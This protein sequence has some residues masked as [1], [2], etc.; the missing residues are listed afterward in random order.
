MCRPVGLGNFLAGYHRVLFSLA[1]RAP[2]FE[3]LLL[4]W[5][6]LAFLFWYVKIFYKLC[7]NYPRIQ[8]IKIPM[9]ILEPLQ[10]IQVRNS[11][12][13]RALMEFQESA[14]IE[15]HAGYFGQK[16]RG[17]VNGL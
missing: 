5:V 7:Y 12:T 4:L 16:T 8:H 17:Y 1:L 11:N 13:Q 3:I 14:G 9:T 10:I 15:P 2:I 6:M